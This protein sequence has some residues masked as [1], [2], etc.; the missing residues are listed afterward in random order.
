MTKNYAQ[1]SLSKKL[2]MLRERVDGPLTQEAVATYLHVSLT[3]VNNWEKGIASP[4][5]FNLRKIITL[6]LSRG[7]FTIGKERQEARQL[8]E[9]SRVAADFDE[10]WFSRLLDQ[11]RQG[12]LEV[13]N[14]TPKEADSSPATAIEVIPIQVEATE[15]DTLN[16][17]LLAALQDGMV[18]EAEGQGELH[19]VGNQG[20][21][22]EIFMSVQ[23]HLA[24]SDEQRERILLITYSNLHTLVTEMLQHS[25][26]VRLEMREMPEAVVSPSQTF[27]ND[28]P[29]RRI[30]SDIMRIYDRTAGAFLLLGTPGSG[31][32][33]LLLELAGT[34]FKRASQDERHPVPFL[35]NLSSWAVR[36]LPLE[37]WMIGELNDVYQVPREIGRAWVT[38]GKI[39]P[40][41]DGL[42]EVAAADYASCIG[43]INDFRHKQ[44]LLP[45]VVCSRTANYLAQKQR[46]WLRG[47][48]EVQPLTSEQVDSY[49]AQVRVEAAS[50]AALRV[51][52][53]EDARLQEMVSTPLI[54]NI[55]TLVYR[56]RA[57]E[58]LSEIKSADPGQI[59]THY[60]ERMLRRRKN[61]KLYRPEKIIR[62]LSWL[63]RQMVQRHQSEFHFERL[64]IDWLPEKFLN[65]LLPI[66]GVGIVYGLFLGIIKGV[67]YAFL[68]GADQAGR[69]FGPGRGLLD[70]VMIGL[71]TVVVFVLLNG[72]ITA[73]RVRR[74]QATQMKGW[75][76]VLGGLF[77]KRLVYGVVSGFFSALAIT[78]LVDLAAG[79]YN[80]LFCCVIFASLG[81]LDTEI[82]PAEVISWSWTPIRRNAGKFLGAGM[83]LGLAYGLL[84]GLYWEVKQYPV[85]PGLRVFIPCLLFGL[86]LGLVL[87][88]LIVLTRG[89]SHGRLKQQPKRP[90]QGIW[91]SLQYSLLL[92]GGSF[93]LFG[94]FFGIFYGVLLYQIFHFFNVPYSEYNGYFP[95]DSGLVIG[96]ADG[97]AVGAFFWLN[98]GG[99]ACV[100][101]LVLRLLLWSGDYAP[102]NYPRFLDYAVEH[103]LLRRVGGGYTFFHKLVQ[104]HFVWLYSQ[105]TLGNEE[106][107]LAVQD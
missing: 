2:A 30:F 29:V 77:E 10:E 107:T 45:L 83:V 81:P 82:R 51:A 60:I 39:L 6:Y 19:S 72:L 86:S 64:Q 26:Y 49:L 65:Q 44:G 96:F 57:A 56:G 106:R 76:H 54:L 15:S 95:R 55:L 80:G 42:D 90:N 50:V 46:L 53:R 35:F 74:R 1:Q 67:N 97:L 47:A 20:S 17:P 40:L 103:I 32:T 85:M 48:V 75:L 93:L 88:L 68:K 31:K 61:K 7:A 52:I 71:V 89:V 4:R 27:S 84:T 94:L 36:Q 3:T 104:E 105:S 59:F 66:L 22:R 73:H 63:A 101:H 43:A 92:G 28:E 69:N 62:W 8:W 14:S 23:P 79:L 24:T 33:F 91:N 13:N 99:T 12:T 25:A 70:G 102:W 87:G 11:H 38:A 78:L 5:A 41:L 100:L 21:V 58:D 18:I 37:Q 98:K 34:L 9:E 16:P